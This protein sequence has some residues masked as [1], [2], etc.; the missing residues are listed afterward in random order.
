MV[1]LWKEKFPV[2]MYTKLELKKYDFYVIVSKIND[3]ANVVLLNDM[4]IS[5]MFI[6]TSI[7]L[8]LSDDTLLYLAVSS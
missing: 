2:N 3:K 6:V 1:F 5:R 7:Y 8:F 4:T